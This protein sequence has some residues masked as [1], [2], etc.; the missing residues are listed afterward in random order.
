MTLAFALPRPTG[1]QQFALSRSELREWLG[2]LPADNAAEA[3]ACLGQQLFAM[4][5]TSLPARA[6]IEFADLFREKM[7]T[8]LPV[9]EADLA[10]AT[11]PLSGRRREAA[12]LTDQLL[13]EL[14]YAY[15]SGV[16]ALSK[17]FLGIGVRGRLQSALLHAMR[18]L[19][20]RLASGY[21]IYAANPK[22]VW[23]ELHLLFELAAKHGLTETR[24]PGTVDTPSSVYRQA[25][26]L[27][28][29]VPHKLMQGDIDRILNYLA[30]F[31][32]RTKLVPP[33]PD[34]EEPGAF[35][36]QP[37]RDAP[38]SAIA[39]FRFAASRPNDLVLNCLPLVELLLDQI[40][41]LAAGIPA[42]DIGLPPEADAPIFRDLLQR[43]ARHWGNVA[44]RQFGRLR[45]HARVELLVGLRAIWR[46]LRRESRLDRTGT[47]PSAWMV[48]NESPGGYALM[49]VSG[50]CEPIR[51]GEVVAVDTGEACHI[52]VV[53]WVLSDNPEHLELGVQEFAPSATPIGLQG[54]NA[55]DSG[56]ALLL[57]EIPALHQPWAILAPY[58]QVDASR[59]LLIAGNNSR[60]RVRATR[61]VEQTLSVQMF[62]FCPA[63]G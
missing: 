10:R 38:G 52:C 9:L 4:N 7:D 6:R 37:D 8:L 30:R 61:I 44:T 20:R 2:A 49:H 29:A 42:R 25:L 1:N 53:R 62:Q 46:S 43:L 23:Q 24:L 19:A 21:R 14:G 63:G 27:A 58:G 59:E 35:L 3:A 60:L 31:A 16:V 17:R 40:D 34:T 39:K 33:S 12:A 22:T 47:A 51:V 45:T 41:K 57:P 54:E 28:F 48:T 15:K 55:S 26:L 5:R 32:D 13:V 36:I 11:L 18:A 56:P 50:R